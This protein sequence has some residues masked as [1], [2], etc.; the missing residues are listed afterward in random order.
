MLL[1]RLTF[2][3][4]AVADNVLP[5]RVGWLTKK[6]SKDQGG[7]GLFFTDGDS[8]PKEQVAGA[9]VKE[10]VVKQVAALNHYKQAKKL[11]KQGQSDLGKV[12]MALEHGPLLGHIKVG[13]FAAIHSTCW[14][15]I[16]SPT[17][18]KCTACAHKNT[19]EQSPKF[20]ACKS[21]TATSREANHDLCTR[22]HMRHAISA[23]RTK[24]N[25][26]PAL[27]GTNAAQK[28]KQ[29]APGLRGGKKGGGAVGGGGI[30]TTRREKL[31]PTTLK[32][33]IKDAFGHQ[34]PNGQWVPD[35]LTTHGR[36]VAIGSLVAVV[37]LVLFCKK[38][39]IAPEAT[40][41]YS[42]VGAGK[43]YSSGASVPAAG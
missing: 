10:Q 27:F 6:A 42:S 37:A 38:N 36:V 28:T 12:D 41:G 7:G 39:A 23:D 16:Q 14:Q 9:A 34:S 24:Q 1:L 20:G 32:D 26:V 22:I 11:D 4:L 35:R 8:D 21:L 2:L 3:C 30:D 19:L 15:D 43:K 40:A 31:S 5:S 13:C 18:D 29:A 17:V 25:L 33:E